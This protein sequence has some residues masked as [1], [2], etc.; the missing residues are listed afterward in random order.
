MNLGHPDQ[1]QVINDSDSLRFKWNF[2]NNCP[3]TTKKTNRNKIVLRFK[4]NEF[5]LI[6]SIEVKLGESFFF[7]WLKTS[8]ITWVLRDFASS[9]DINNKTTFSFHFQTSFHRVEAW[10]F[11]FQPSPL[12]GNSTPSFSLKMKSIIYEAAID[13]DVSS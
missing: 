8:K 11:S 13:F 1:V 6:S 7:I 9:P 12:N 3:L 4:T 5:F 2:E 10:Y